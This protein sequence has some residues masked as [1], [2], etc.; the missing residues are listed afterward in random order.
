MRLIILLIYL[1]CLVATDEVKSKDEFYTLSFYFFDDNRKVSAGSAT[2][3]FQ[4][5]NLYSYNILN[6]KKHREVLAVAIAASNNHVYYW[7]NTGEVSSGDTEYMVRHRNFY[8]SNQSPEKQLIAA[9][10]ASNDRV[11]YWYSDDTA[12]SGTT[13]NPTRYRKYYPVDIRKNISITDTPNL[14]LPEAIA[15]AKG[16]D[17]VH[18]FYENGTYDIGTTDDADAHW[19][20][21][22][23]NRA[24]RTLVD[25]D[26]AKE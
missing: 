19:K 5:R 23:F 15:I 13:D 24:G 25:V 17:R 10:I 7:Y 2:N 20:N 14:V 3:P 21:I 18:Y 16:D 8:F 9:A 1:V 22:R 12:S 26:S 11:Y 4:S 6:E